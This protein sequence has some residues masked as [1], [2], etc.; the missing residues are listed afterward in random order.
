MSLIAKSF[1]SLGIVC[2]L[3]AEVYAATLFHI[4]DFESGTTEGWDGAAPT[5]QPSGGP[6][7][8]ND[9]FLEVVSTVAALLDQKRLRLTKRRIG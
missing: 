6:L 5:N 2:L 3:G 9:N 8:V 4:N 1:L 7:G